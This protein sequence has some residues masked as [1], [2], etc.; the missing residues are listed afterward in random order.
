MA[1][2]CD[3]EDLKSS[4]LSN[5]SIDRRK[6]LHGDDFVPMNFSLLC[7]PIHCRYHFYAI[8]PQN[9]LKKQNWLQFVFVVKV[10][11]LKQQQM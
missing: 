1:D 4:Y 8:E 11:A 2:G 3:V 5:G 9:Y 10:A 6:I 7:Q